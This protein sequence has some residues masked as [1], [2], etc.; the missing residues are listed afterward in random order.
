M[1]ATM[2]TKK[3]ADYFGVSETLAVKGNA[4]PLEIQHLQAPNPD[5]AELALSVVEHIHE[6][7]PPG[8]I[9]VFLASAQQVQIAILKL[10]KI[11]I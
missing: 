5:Y 1:S 10:R 11:A 3:F 4:F 7:K 6:N 2:N 9:L 8:N